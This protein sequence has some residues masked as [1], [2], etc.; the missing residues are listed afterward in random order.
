MST[1][2][3]IFLNEQER[4]LTLSFAQQARALP[5]NHNRDYLDAHR[6]RALMMISSPEV[7]ERREA[8]AAVANPLVL[9]TFNNI[10]DGPDIVAPGITVKPRSSNNLG[11]VEC[12]DFTLPIA[13]CVGTDV[14]NLYGAD[15]FKKSEIVLV[16][17]RTDVEPDE[18]HRPDFAGWHD[19]LSSPMGEI[20][21]I[22]SFCAALGEPGKTPTSL[23]TEFRFGNQIIAVPENSLTRFGA[24][25]PHRSQVN[26]TG[27]TVRRLWGA[28]IVVNGERPQTRYDNRPYNI[29]TD[30]AQVRQFRHAAQHYLENTPVTFTPVD[31]PSPLAAVA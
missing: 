18:A 15:R 22:Y 31:A 17:Q 12:Y 27:E 29:G 6:A 26:K 13:Q 24:E 21:L 19:H 7:R 8:R 25:F 5:T 1:I 11:V 23:P 14:L 10:P 2:N 3:T 20:D 16:V 9:G 4:G 30:S 28:F